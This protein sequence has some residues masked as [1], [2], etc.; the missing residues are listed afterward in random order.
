MNLIHALNDVY[1]NANM[2]ESFRV[3][4][5]GTQ[6]AVV[7]YTPAYADNMRMRYII[8]TFPTMEEAKNALHRLMI[9][10]STP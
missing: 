1:I 10:I 4:S 8:D 5:V 9:N 6:F 3:R 2:V 7:A